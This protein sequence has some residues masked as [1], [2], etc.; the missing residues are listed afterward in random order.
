TNYGFTDILAATED[1][2]GMYRPRTQE[3]RQVWDKVLAQTRVY[4]GD[5]TPEVLMSAA[6]EALG[7]LK[8][9]ELKD[10]DKKKQVEQLFG[11]TVGEAE[12]SRFVQL[13]RQITDFG[14]EEEDEGDQQMDVD[15]GGIAVVFG[16]SDDEDQALGGESGPTSHVVDEESSDES[17]DDDQVGP[18]VPMGARKD[19]AESDANTE[20][21]DDEAGGYRTVIHGF[22][23]KNAK[24]LNRRNEERAKAAA[25]AQTTTTSFGA[26]TRNEPDTDALK[27]EPQLVARN[28]DAFWLQR[29]VGKHY[30]EP[31]VVQE[32]TREATRL[33]SSRKLALGEVENELAELFEYEHFET[34]QLLVS[35]RDMIVWCMRI[36]RAESEG[37]EEQ[38]RIVKEEMRELGLDWIIAARNGEAV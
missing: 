31:T 38:M 30:T 2:E 37:D 6:D 27:D 4:L 8:N 9:E 20:A 1:M 14:A 25:A 5:Q 24:Q 33:L 36:A 17:S 16:G 21:G 19:A 15:E 28:I 35:N 29:Q 22:G 12:F 3:T 18:A 11:A 26:D 23:E 7:V 10:M 32:K 34:V 13:A